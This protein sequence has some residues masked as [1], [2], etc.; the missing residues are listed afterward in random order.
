MDLD[1]K[2][3]QPG[4]L[5]L[6][7]LQIAKANIIG[8]HVGVYCG[9]GEIIHFLAVSDTSVTEMLAEDCE[10]VVYKEGLRQLRRTRKLSRVLRKRG[11]VD[12][13][14]LERRVREA[15]NED[16]PRYHLK[17]SNCIHFALKLL[18]MD[19]S[20][21]TSKEDATQILLTAVYSRTLNNLLIEARIASG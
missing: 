20:A 8:A 12:T 9:N 21:L 5:F 17:D 3:P 14:L 2:E 16:P 15:M 19:S 18:D 1:K 4:D 6:F 7:E 10:G 13:K 11:G